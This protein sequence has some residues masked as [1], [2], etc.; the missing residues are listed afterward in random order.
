MLDA[1]VCENFADATENNQ[2]VARDELIIEVGEQAAVAEVDYKNSQTVH[3]VAWNIERGS[4]LHGII[5][6]FRAHPVL[7]TSDLLMLT[8][9]DWGMARS[10]NRLVPR[11]IAAALRLNYVFAPCY[12]ALNK[13][14]GL[15]AETEGENGEALHGNALM[16]RYTLKRAHSLALPNGKDKLA[17]REKRLGSQRAVIADVEHPAGEFRAVSLHLDAHATQAHRHLQMRLLLDHLEGLEPQMPVLVGGDW[18]TITYNSSRAFY[19]IMG[20]WRSVVV[21]GVRQT[22]TEHLP[23]PDRRFERGLF[24][25]LESRGFVYKD[26]NQTGGCTLHYDV[27]DLAT[28]KNMREWVP[29][30]CFDFIE[31]ALRD[32]DGRCS[33]KLDWFAGKNIAPVDERFAPHVIGDLRDATTGAPL[34]DHDAIALDFRLAPTAA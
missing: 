12:I 26:L 23:Y 31:W 24:R 22:L 9:L 14:S 4:R 33:L 3:T 2:R 17:G 25:E 29:L 13:G 19:A 34:S 18:N 11:E 10:A 32:H 8:E 7:R 21:T 16:S 6:A 30:W 5:E 27:K 28:F 15:E 1:V 20:F